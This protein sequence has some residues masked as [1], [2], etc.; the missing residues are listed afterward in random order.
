ML[1]RKIHRDAIEYVNRVRLL[2][3]KDPIKD[4]PVGLRFDEHNSPIGKVIQYS[5]L[6]ADLAVDE[7]DQVANILAGG[8][9]ESAELWYLLFCAGFYSRYNEARFYAELPLKRRQRLMR[10]VR[11]AITI[12]PMEAKERYL[13]TKALVDH[14]RRQ[15]PRAT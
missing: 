1:L 3:G 10:T 4:F 7:G 13:R 8:T 14:A 2:E 15:L 11:D 9:A 6:S 5:R 12:A